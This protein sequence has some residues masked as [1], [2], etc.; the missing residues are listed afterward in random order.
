MTTREIEFDPEKAAINLQVH[1]INFED[2]ALVFVD[3]LRIER[4][5]DSEGKHSRGRTLSNPEH[6]G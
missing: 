2:A 1:K 5:D 6:G 4:R 3:P